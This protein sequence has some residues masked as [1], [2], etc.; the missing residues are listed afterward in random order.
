MP[1]HRRPILQLISRRS[2]RWLAA[3]GMH[4]ADMA[5]DLRSTL[6]DRQIK[7]TGDGRP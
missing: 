7:L 5:S 2:T 1:S 4:F 6:S 3:S